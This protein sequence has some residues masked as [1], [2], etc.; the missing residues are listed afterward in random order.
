MSA[1][2]APP[3]DLLVRTISRSGGIAVRAL[4]ATRLVAE[5]AQR[6]ATSPVASIALGRALMG[7]V[8]L[9]SSTKR[10]TVQIE[11][12][13]DGPL[14]SLVAIADPQ[15]RARGYVSRPFAEVPPDEGRIDVAA[16]V[17]RG[18]L[19]CVRTTAGSPTPASYRSW[20]EPS[21]GIAHYLAEQQIPSAVALGVFL[22]SDG[23]IARPATTSVGRTGRGRDGDRACGRHV[24]GLPARGQRARDGFDA[25]AIAAELL[26][27]LRRRR[28]PRHDPRFRTAAQRER[29][30]RA[31]ALLGRGIRARRAG[32]RDAR[33]APLRRQLCRAAERPGGWSRRARQL[34]A[35]TPLATARDRPRHGRVGLLGR[36]VRLFPVA[37]GLR[38]RPGEACC[39]AAEPRRAG[40]AGGSTCAACRC[41]TTSLRAALRARRARARAAD[42]VH[43][44]VTRAQLDRRARRLVA[45]TAR[46]HPAHGSRV[47]RGPRALPLHASRGAPSRSRRRW[48]TAAP[49]RIAEAAH[50]HD[51]ERGRRVRCVPAEAA[52]V[53]HARGATRDVVCVL[54][55]AALVRAKGHR[56]CCSSPR[57]A[58]ARSAPLRVWIAG[59]APSAPRGRAGRSASSR[60]SF[61]GR[62]DDKADLLAGCDL[63]VLPSRAGVSA[64]RRWRR[65]PAAARFVASRVGGLNGRRGRRPPGS[66]GAARRRRRIARGARAPGGRRRAARVSAR[67]VRRIAEGQ[68]RADV[69]RA[70]PASTA[71]CCR[72]AAREAPRVGIV[73]A[74][75]QRPGAS[76]PSS[77]A[78]G[79]G[80]R[81]NPVLL[82]TSGVRRDRTRCAGGPASGARLRGARRDAAGE[83]STLSRSSRL[84]PHAAP[85]SRGSPA[86]ACCAKPRVGRRRLA[87]GARRIGGLRRAGCC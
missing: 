19:S 71:S 87:A 60:V 5:A 78:T 26:G 44:H 84:P 74:R 68:R 14:G 43:L 62:R 79:R 67:R 7:A 4:V 75:R 39:C 55:L 35:L 77:R 59:E 64:S 34:T 37:R 41:G 63:L 25:D 36:R 81:R 12:R 52:T 58:A 73:G 27:E 47:T 45:R 80:R 6:H 16:A 22:G 42:L 9:A 76:A 33:C 54:A 51:P 28:A 72:N 20:R 32:G 46:D 21:D 53:R 49:R 66:A 11:L 38:K 2:L 23:A 13:G 86:C 82:T 50:P 15:A 24:R 1:V 65:W 69:R 70:T 40:A 29:V 85:R 30:L 57:A 48:A 31:V 61:L 3:P 56:P 17:G 83:T 18:T 8:L 10:E